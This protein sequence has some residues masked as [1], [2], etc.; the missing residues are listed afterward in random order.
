[1]VAAYDAY[2][3]DVGVIE[4]PEGYSAEDEVLRKSV[5]YILKHYGPFALIPLVLLLLLGVLWRRRRQAK[6]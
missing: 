2:A 6:A 4:M 3:Q 1:M 5:A